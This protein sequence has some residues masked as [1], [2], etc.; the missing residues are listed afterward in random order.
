MQTQPDM[1]KKSL[2]EAT[3]RYLK[4]W[5]IAAYLSRFINAI[6]RNERP[7]NTN[8]QSGAKSTIYQPQS[9]QYFCVTP[10]IHKGIA[11]KPVRKSIVARTPSS[12]FEG[13]CSDRFFS[14]AYKKMPFIITEATAAKDEEVKRTLRLEGRLCDVEYV[15][16]SLPGIVILDDYDYAVH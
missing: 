6:N 9:K 7:I 16:D 4:G 5:H 1:H 3:C 10:V 8:E 2:V 14:N 15:D 12:V 11:I 13:E